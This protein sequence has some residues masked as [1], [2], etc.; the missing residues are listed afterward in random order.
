MGHFSHGRRYA[1][2]MTRQLFC[3]FALAVVA[4]SHAVAQCTNAS[5]PAATGCGWSMPFGIPTVSCAGSPTIGNAT[6]TVTSSPQ[7]LGTATVGILVVGTCR[8][9][10]LLPMGPGAACGPTQA[11]CAQ[12]VDIITAIPGTVSAGGFSFSTPI[13]NIPQLAGLQLCAQSALFCT[14]G[15]VAVSNGLRITLQ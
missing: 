4:A 8:P 3:S 1:G 13:P 14:G 6:F 11:T 12:Y 7:C 15:C 9:A 2:G 10:L 5:I